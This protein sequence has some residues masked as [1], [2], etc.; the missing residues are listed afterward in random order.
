MPRS[1]RLLLGAGISWWLLQ[2]EALL[3]R[4]A[5]NLVAQLTGRELLI[6]GS[7]QITLGSTTTLTASDVHFADA[8]WADSDAM[9]SLENVRLELELMS[10]FADRWRFMLWMGDEAVDVDVLRRMGSAASKV[11]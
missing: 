9:L 10:I 4:Q 2:D 3:K 7:L 8:E 6:D 1:R 11:A 5:S